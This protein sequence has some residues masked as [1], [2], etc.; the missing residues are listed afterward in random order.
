MAVKFRLASLYS[1]VA[2]KIRP[3]RIILYYHKIATKL[4]D[5]PIESCSRLTGELVSCDSFYRQI[6][7]ISKKYQIVTLDEYVDCLRRKKNKKNIAVITFDDAYADVYYNAFPILKE[8]GVPATVF[9]PGDVLLEGNN[10]SPLWI[11]RLFY[12]LDNSKNLNFCLFDSWPDFKLDTIPNKT[13]TLLSLIRIM[14]AK[15][16]EDRE[17]FL[18]D[19]SAMVNVSVVN[20]FFSKQYLTSNQI[21]EMQSYGFSFQPHTMSHPDLGKIN[22][23]EA[24]KEILESREL[25]ESI[26][27][28]KCRYFSYPFGETSTFNNNCITI[29]RKNKFIA[30]VTTNEGF[31][32]IGANPY[33][34]KRVLAP[35]DSNIFYFRISG[36]SALLKRIYYRR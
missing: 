21:S 12:I 15:S 11:D 36:L 1:A 23:K 31:N 17:I 25:I 30:A 20:D 29:L 9:C 4:S 2:R 24:E 6:K 16:R 10:F 7:Y 27:G 33:T 22:A 14:R 32:K 35:Q 3:D 18:S 19:L 28:R 26:T 8:I 5:I 34:L 13:K